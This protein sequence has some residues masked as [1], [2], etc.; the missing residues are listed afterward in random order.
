MHIKLLATDSK[1]SLDHDHRLG[2]AQP[3]MYVYSAK[4]MGQHLQLQ[5]YMEVLPNISVHRNENDTTLRVSYRILSWGG[6]GE[7]DGSRIIAACESMFTHAKVC[8]PTR[9]V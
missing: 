6:G 4:C 3:S 2:C 9:G 7:Q 8:V 5:L 1:L